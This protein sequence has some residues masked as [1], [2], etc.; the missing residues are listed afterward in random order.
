ML[1]V[2]QLMSLMVTVTVQTT[3]VT[4]KFSDLFSR[5]SRRNLSDILTGHSVSDLKEV[6]NILRKTYGVAF[7]NS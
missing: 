4:Q 6:K 7:A 1:S 5:F 2:K 3:W